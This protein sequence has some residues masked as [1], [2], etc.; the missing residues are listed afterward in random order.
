MPRKRRV[1]NPARRST[2]GVRSRHE[3]VARKR[4]ALTQSGTCPDWL[5]PNQMLTHLIAGKPSL[6]WRN[7][8]TC[9]KVPSSVSRRTVRS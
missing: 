7:L 6:V 4:R 1:L 5:T 9:P 3:P 2:P 8:W